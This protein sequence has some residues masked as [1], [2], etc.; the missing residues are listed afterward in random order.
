MISQ[1]RGQW[2][3]GQQQ[4]P[5]KK[6]DEIVNRQESIDIALREQQVPEHEGKLKLGGMAAVDS[7][8]PL[9]P[10]TPGVSRAAT[11]W[12]SSDGV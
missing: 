5:N 1:R 8:M 2:A 9:A 12:G 10:L 3:A 4:L 6:M 7:D 11:F